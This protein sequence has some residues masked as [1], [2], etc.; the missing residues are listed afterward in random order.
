[1]VVQKRGQCGNPNDYFSKNWA[2][3]KQGFQEGCEEW[4]GL[5]RLHEHTSS[6]N[7]GLKVTLTDWNSNDHYAYYDSFIVGQESDNY[8]LSVG[9]FDEKNSTLENAFDCR[10]DISKTNEFSDMVNC[11]FNGA[12]FSTM[13]HD[14]DLWKYSCSNQD[15]FGNLNNIYGGSGGW[16]FF[17]CGASNLN[18]LNGIVNENEYD[19]SRIRWNRNSKPSLYQASK[20]ELVP[21]GKI[22]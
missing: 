12:E 14:N 8:R 19:H 17:K 1:M 13:D 20:M 21:K 11:G 16:W 2:E 5:D 3:Y 10:E 9:M 4:I 22:N 15:D 18:G 6:G 7:Y